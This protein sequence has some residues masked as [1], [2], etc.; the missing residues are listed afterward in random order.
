VQQVLLRAV[1]DGPGVGQPRVRD[2]IDR[3]F[4]HIVSNVTVTCAT[5]GNHGRSVAWGAEMFGCRCVIY[6]PEYTSS[7]RESALVRHGADVVRFPGNYDEAVHRCDE[8]ARRLGRFVVS[9]TSYAGYMEVPK[10]VMQGYTVMVAEAI[11]QLPT[12]DRPT[13]VF[14][15]G[16]VGGLAASVCGHIWEAWGPERPTLTVVEPDS[17]DCLYR[18]AQA[19]RPT[20]VPGAYDSIMAGLAAGEVSLLAWQILEGGADAFMTIPDAAAEATMR[21]LAAATGGDP[22]IVAGESGAAGLAGA[23]LALGD[24]GARQTL[25][26]R[27]DSRTLVFGTEGATDPDSYQRIVGRSA[28]EV[29]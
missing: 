3:R 25:G 14:V 4:E 26:L 27:P 18:S 16:G 29:Q 5:A 15:Q 8:D 6:I 9:D 22:P 13:H 24:A 19:G 2:L 17:A 28:G 11:E 7:H 23:L 1:R 20:P 10:H 21:L 12:G